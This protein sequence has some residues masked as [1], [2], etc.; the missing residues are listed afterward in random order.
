M[1][2]RP[3]DCVYEHYL[4]IHRFVQFSSDD[5][6]FNRIFVFCVSQVFQ[7]FDIILGFIK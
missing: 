5:L 6:Y 7:Y 4:I 1:I 3:T 2:V